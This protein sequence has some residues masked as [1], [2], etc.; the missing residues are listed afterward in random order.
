ME[1]LIR[2]R[3]SL[4]A[5][6]IL[7]IA[8]GKSSRY[9]SFGQESLNNS[10]VALTAGRALA[11]K[12]CT[13]CHIFPEP[14]LLDQ[15]TYNY[16]LT[17]MGLLMGFDSSATLSDP[18][19]L[20]HFRNRFQLLSRTGRIPPKPLLPKADFTSLRNFYLANALA[21]NKVSIPVERLSG[22]PIKFDFK[23]PVVTMAKQISGT[24]YLA[25]GGGT[26]HSLQILDKDQ[27]VILETTFASPPVDVVHHQDS[28]FVVTLGDLLGGI[29]G[30]NKAELWQLS[31]AKKTRLLSRL[32]RTTQVLL[33][34]FDGDHKPDFLISSFGNQEDGKL[35]WYGFVGGA[36]R[37]HVIAK[38]ASIVRTAI[39]SKPGVLPVKLIALQAGAREQ[40]VL[41]TINKS[42]IIAKILA[43]FPPSYG[44][45]WL[46][47]ADMD[48]DKQD[49]ILVLSGD[50]ADCGPYNAL[51]PYQGL[52]VY[53]FKSDAVTLRNFFPVQGAL[54]MSIRSATAGRALQILI[55][56][57][58][59]D[60]RSPRDLVLFE[61][62]PTGEWQQKSY[63][64]NSRLTVGT[65]VGETNKVLVGSGNTPLRQRVGD[66]V[67]V[68]QF[69]GPALQEVELR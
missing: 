4:T 2:H 61:V 37:E 49:E 48:G 15:S 8:C 69:D 9:T 26:L 64:L 57:Y 23:D 35:S 14:D 67:S 31:A 51:K 20:A 10:D 6:L 29:G 1:Y 27:K 40:L 50:D 34:D 28:F 32:A 45:V 11:Q 25:V 56:A 62:S 60:L 47:K 33:H 16:A 42:N 19:D 58:Y 41:Y 52:R 36:L 7:T 59:A 43:E 68:R 44:S 46:E 63:F 53:D 30:A 13:Q 5:F 66:S 22:A 17:Y 39:A 12:H 3:G 24:P 65:W 54:S 18:F 55:F 38:N 21:E